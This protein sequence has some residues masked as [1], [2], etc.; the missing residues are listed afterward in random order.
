L[1]LIPGDSKSYVTLCQHPSDL[2]SSVARFFLDVTLSD[3]NIELQQFGRIIKEWS[4]CNEIQF[5][6]ESSI[7]GTICNNKS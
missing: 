5:I 7:T 4:N 2:V 6:L 1:E 3:F